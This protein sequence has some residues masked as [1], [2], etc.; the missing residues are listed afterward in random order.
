MS[1][2]IL[3]WGTYN[4]LNR[5]G[6]SGALIFFS[7]LASPQCFQWGKCP[8][9]VNLD[10]KPDGPVPWQVGYGHV[11]WLSQLNSPAWAEI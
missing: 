2:I 4:E 7:Y 8:H 3:V 1:D 10:G 6:F 9:C 5:C 11:T